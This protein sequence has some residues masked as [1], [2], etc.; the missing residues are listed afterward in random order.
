MIKISLA[1][2]FLSV[3]FTF[4]SDVASRLD[5]GSLETSK[6][7]QL[8]YKWSGASVDHGERG[9]SRQLY[10][11]SSGW[12]LKSAGGYAKNTFQSAKNTAHSKAR[13]ENI[14]EPSTDADS[15][16]S[17]IPVTPTQAIDEVMSKGKSLTVVNAW[18]DM[19]LASCLGMFQTEPQKPETSASQPNPDETVPEKNHPESNVLVLEIMPTAP[20]A[21]STPGAPSISTP[22]AVGDAKSVVGTIT[23]FSI[24]SMVPAKGSLFQMPKGCGTDPIDGLKPN[25]NFVA[26]PGSDFV[27]SGIGA[28][29]VKLSVP[30]RHDPSLPLY[31]ILEFD[32]SERLLPV[33]VKKDEAA[34][35][36]NR[37][38]DIEPAKA[39]L[40][41]GITHATRERQ[42]T[43]IGPSRSGYW[44][45]QIALHFVDIIIVHSLKETYFLPGA[46]DRHNTMLMQIQ[47]GPIPEVYELTFPQRDKIRTDFDRQVNHRMRT[48]DPNYKDKMNRFTNT[49]ITAQRYARTQADSG[50]S[51]TKQPFTMPRQQQQ[52]E[53]TPA[54]RIE[55]RRYS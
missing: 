44:T 5:T 1:K 27:V 23:K 40:A 51:Q 53:P 6:S 38:M 45:E 46:E 42:I 39:L 41:E 52:P 34:G 36:L 14:N 25:T 20:D 54:S 47:Q 29:V 43:L 17:L 33:M 28:E 30:L 18:G 26:P 3:L 48:R 12:D 55:H 50:L 37:K 11:G 4:L 24:K 32:P 31:A 9:Q 13:F 35:E 2:L 16:T 19:D 8:G 22:S 10:T 21:P 49:P 15:Y 7:A